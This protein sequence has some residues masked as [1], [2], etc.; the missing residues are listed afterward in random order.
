MPS[1]QKRTVDDIQAS[2]KR[3]LIRCDFN[4]PLQNG[5]I[6]D[7]NRVI[8][9]LPTIQKVMQ[10]GGKVI[11]CSHLG[12]PKGE[13]KP[14]CS[15]AP[16][17]TLLS[18]LLGKTVLFAADDNV[19]GENAKK[20]MAAMQN[21]DVVLLENTR[22]RAEETKNG[23]AFSRDLASLCDVFVNDAFGTA[24]RAHCST[25]GVVS[26]VE[27]ACLGYLMEKEV[28]Y[29]G[30]AVNHPTRPL[31]TILGGAKVVDKLKVIDHL[32]DKTDTLIIG[33][34]MA[35]TFLAAQGFSIGKSLVD[36]EKIDYCAQM[37]K[38]AEQKGVKL[39][40]PVD[41][42]AA[43]SFPNPITAPMEAQVYPSD[44]LPDDMMAMD[45]G[46]ES[47]TVFAEAAKTAKTVVWNGPMGVF[48][49]ETFA[50]GTKA[51]AEALAQ[52][53]AIT[54]IGGGDSVAAVN[55]MGLGDKMSHISTGGG[56]SLEFL[57]GK[58][59]PGIDCIKDR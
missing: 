6:T 58:I 48:E 15:L 19:V 4:V 26:F 37:I 56:A 24:H 38:K 43:A 33:G 16:V 53:D 10:D 46:P 41:C 54:I 14:E 59:L 8:G 9:A 57:E 11:L 42:R 50:R 45:I 30:A 17:A 1:F 39:L 51:V 55:Q 2:G 44:G 25:V 31:V 47:E 36:R 34:G 40:L 21:G 49:N 28:N 5:E 23:E 18:E 13:P 20:A 27:D 7:Q 12:K 35:Y 29:L 32:L 3:V 52:T 22:Y